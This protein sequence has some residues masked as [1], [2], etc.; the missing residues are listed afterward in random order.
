ML[1]VPAPNDT[2]GRI[3]VLGNAGYDI[4]LTLPRMPRYG[5]SLLGSTSSRAPGGKGLNQAVVAARAGARVHFTAPIGDD[6]QGEGVAGW[7]AQEPFARLELSRLPH[8]TDY[9]L[10]MVFPD[11][12]NSVIGTGPCAAAFPASAAAEACA[13]LH[14][15]DLLVVQGNLSFDA[16]FAALSTARARGA[17]TLLNPSPLWWDSTPLLPLCSII[18]ANRPEAATITHTDD[19]RQALAHLA[20]IGVE[21]A[22]ITLGAE[23]C[24]LQTDGVTQPYAAPAIKAV[25]TTGCGDTFCGVFASMLM[26]GRDMPTAIDLAQHAAALTAT[27]PGAFASL[28]ARTELEALLKTA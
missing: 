21:I 24:L 23:G 27:R 1:N 28:P 4:G 11:G 3:F 22:L 15:S 8:P 2:Q 7:L 14:S 19:P 9:S 20:A 18:I 6:T 25:D 16:T 5:E 17:R 26:A 12:E 13:G 10:L